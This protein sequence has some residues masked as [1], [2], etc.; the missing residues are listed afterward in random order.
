M[1]L[2]GGGALQGSN[3]LQPSIALECREPERERVQRKEAT[4]KGPRFDERNPL[5]VEGIC[6]CP[7]FPFRES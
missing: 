1:S 2:G 3:D 6:S 7:A 4:H 5:L